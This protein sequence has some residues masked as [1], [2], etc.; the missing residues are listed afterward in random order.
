[1]PN[2]D[3]AQA[4]ATD[5]PTAP[6]SQAAEE[7]PNSGTNNPMADYEAKLAKAM[8]AGEEPEEQGEQPAEGETAADE[9]AEEQ[10]EDENTSGDEQTSDEETPTEEEEEEPDTKLPDRFRFKSDEDRAVAALAKAEGISLVEAAGRYSTLKAP[11]KR[12]DGDTPSNADKIETSESVSE[13]IQALIAKKDELYDAL[14][15]TSA[16][17]LDAEI[18]KLREKRFALMLSENA[19]QAQ[20]KTRAEQSAMEKFN[21]DWHASEQKTIHFYPDAAKHDTAFAKE[22]KRVEAEMQELGDDLYH[23]ADKP[24]IVAKRAAKNLVFQ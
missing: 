22:M 11:T 19:A 20:A 23:S 2:K 17:G 18:E 9:Q 16:K 12:E 13:Q 10:E 24:W 1:M 3:Q 6:E 5:Q 15:F 4:D 7:S 8:S 21:A 14:E